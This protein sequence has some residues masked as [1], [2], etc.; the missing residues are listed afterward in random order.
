MSEIYNFFCGGMVVFSLPRALS[1]EGELLRQHD[2]AAVLD[3]LH[4]ALLELADLV[5]QLGGH[6]GELG[7]LLLEL[8][9]LGVVR[10]EGQLVIFVL[11]L[12]L[13]AMCDQ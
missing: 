1:S 2:L 7:V 11:P 9:H 12:Q 6:V 5:P 4:D 3:V 13:L 10:V 8:L